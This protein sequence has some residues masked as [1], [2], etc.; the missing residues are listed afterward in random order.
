MFKITSSDSVWEMI[1]RFF[2]FQTATV[3]HAALADIADCLHSS[4]RIHRESGCV[5]WWFRTVKG[6]AL[7]ECK[8][9]GRDDKCGRRVRQS[10]HRKKVPEFE[11]SDEGKCVLRGGK[12]WK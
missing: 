3:H 12:G 4:M 5:I 11:G 9:A 10:W 7:C 2:A 8:G 1:N 6:I